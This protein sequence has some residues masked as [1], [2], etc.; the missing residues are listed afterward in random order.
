MIF[1]HRGVSPWDGAPPGAPTPTMRAMAAFR[2]SG[3]SPADWSTLA[4]TPLPSRA[5]P[6]SRCSLPT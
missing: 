6:S 5:R 1:L 3:S 2:L 4:A